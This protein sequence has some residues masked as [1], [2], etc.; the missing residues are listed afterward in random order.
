MWGSTEVVVYLGGPTGSGKSALAVALAQR[1][2]G[3]LVNADSQQVYRGLDL[4]TGKPT[5]EERQNV[6]HHLYDLIEPDEQLDA[7]A[8]A[9]EAQRCLDDIA[10]RG[11][12]PIVV[13]GT[14]LW[15]RALYKGLVDAPPRNE[16]LRRRLEDDARTLGLAALHAR[17][18][19]VDPESAGRI[20]PTD[21]V[22]IIRALEVFELTGVTQSALHRQHAQGEPRHRAL[23]VALDWP[24]ETLGSRLRQRVEHM[25]ERGL[26]EET[27]RLAQVPSTRQKLEKVMGYREALAH[28]EGAMSKEEAIEAI[29]REHRRYAKRQRTWL[30]GESWWQWV[31][32]EEAAHRVPVLVETSLRSEPL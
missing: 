24:A 22:R 6:A 30:R 2:D 11:R 9:K 29:T 7:A 12:L 18:T 27:R 10:A 32:A 25:F 15:M 28:L 5:A 3:E 23:H 14:G 16:A 1:F 19:D 26:L 17:L 4:G 13:G 31:P 20:H 8:W 21:P